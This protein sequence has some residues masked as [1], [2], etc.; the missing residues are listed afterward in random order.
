MINAGFDLRH[1]HPIHLAIG[2][3]GHVGDVSFVTS[4]ADPT[5]LRSALALPGVNRCLPEARVRE[6]I[7]LVRVPPAASGQNDDDGRADAE[8][9]LGALRLGWLSGGH[10]RNRVIGWA[11]CGAGAGV[12]AAATGVPHFGQNLSAAV[13]AA[14]QC[15][16]YFII[17][18]PLSALNIP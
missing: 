11:A 5:K 15:S 17:I 9:P 2:R 4:R 13:K 8:Q 7:Q 6:I 16:Q 14:P 12:V 10:R 1:G 3:E 18:P